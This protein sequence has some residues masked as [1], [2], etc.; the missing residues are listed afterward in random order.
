MLEMRLI[1]EIDAS[2]ASGATRHRRSHGFVQ[3]SCRE[4]LFQ[5]DDVSAAVIGLTFAAPRLHRRYALSSSLIHVAE[6]NAATVTT[7]STM[8]SSIFVFYYYCEWRR[9]EDGPARLRYAANIP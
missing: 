5:A 6:I 9:A 3:L 1:I 7:I 8:G 2:L 4:L